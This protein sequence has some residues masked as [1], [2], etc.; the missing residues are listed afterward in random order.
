[1]VIGVQVCECT[2]NPLYK[3]MLYSTQIIS[4]LKSSKFDCGDCC[5]T[6]NVLKNFEGTK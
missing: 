5:T 2:L 1:M 3:G 4:Q 6:P